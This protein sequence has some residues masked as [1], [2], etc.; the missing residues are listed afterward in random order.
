MKIYRV[1]D[2]GDCVLTTF[3]EL[4]A[5]RRFEA[6]MTKHDVTFGWVDTEEVK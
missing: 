4:V 6:I 1:I 5:L 3:D 2:D